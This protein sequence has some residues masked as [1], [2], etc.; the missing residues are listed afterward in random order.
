MDESGF[1]I[2]Q[3]DVQLMEMVPNQTKQTSEERK[4]LKIKHF[5]LCNFLLTPFDTNINYTCKLIYIKV[6][7]KCGVNKKEQHESKAK[8]LF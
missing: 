8:H 4:D 5:F 1:M 3:D 7:M 2:P 6:V